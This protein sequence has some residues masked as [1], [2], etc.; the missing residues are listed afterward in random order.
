VEE[1]GK[2]RNVGPREQHLG[3][4][5]HGVGPRRLAGS[6]PQPPLLNGAIL[7]Q[8]GK[9]RANGRRVGFSSELGRMDKPKHTGG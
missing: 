8:G 9:L 2:D 7:L 4:G 3:V 6:A 5:R 1:L